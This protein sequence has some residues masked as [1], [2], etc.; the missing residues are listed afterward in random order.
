MLK[1][2]G[3]N[4]GYGSPFSFPGTHKAAFTCIVPARGLSEQLQLMCTG[5]SASVPFF[6]SHTCHRATLP[7]PALSGTSLRSM[8]PGDWW[9]V[10]QGTCSF[11]PCWFVR[12]GEPS[13]GPFSLMVLGNGCVQLRTGQ[14]RGGG[15]YFRAICELWI[16]SE[17]GPMK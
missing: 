11:T 4:I 1:Y 12:E 14:G 16:V 17:V 7:P 5:L 3:T 13:H 2:V 9:L 6:F 10:T 8:F 15:G